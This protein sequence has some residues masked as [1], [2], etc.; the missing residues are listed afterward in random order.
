MIQRFLRNY[1]LR[2]QNRSNQVLHLIG[3][4][5]AFGGFIGFGLTEEPLIAGIALISGYALQFW[6]HF[7]EQNDAGELILI[8]RMLGKP[9]TRFG[10]NPQN[11]LNF[12]QSSKKSSCND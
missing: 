7:L 11:R 6:G 9:Y 3:V 10:P 4:P 8:K 5:L 2:H 12:D 1:L